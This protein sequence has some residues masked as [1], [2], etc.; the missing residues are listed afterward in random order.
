M[1]AQNK[2]AGAAGDGGNRSEDLPHP[3]MM[4]GG[5]YRSK[6]LL[7]RLRLHSR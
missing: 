1:V 3:D 5:P 2:K 6:G 4:P 7:P